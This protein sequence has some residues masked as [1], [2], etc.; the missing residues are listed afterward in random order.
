[1]IGAWPATTEDLSLNATST[2]DSENTFNAINDINS[3]RVVTLPIINYKF[4]VGPETLLL[5]VMMISGAIGACVYSL[6][7]ASTHLGRLHDFNYDRWKAWYV[8][9]PIVG[10]GLAL[11]FY[12][13]IRGGLL[14]VGA[15]FM[16]LNL[17]VIAGLS[18][19]VGM[20]SEQALLKLSELADATFGSA[21]KKEPSAKKKNAKSEGEGT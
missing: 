21:P 6:W 10:A 15:E 8:T 11:F 3:T 17:V 5:F 13:L 20:F 1:M 7:A 19:L 2:L 14:T 12:L 18:G 16:T 4:Y 9:R